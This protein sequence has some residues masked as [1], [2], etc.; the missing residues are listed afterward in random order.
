MLASPPIIKSCDFDGPPVRS[1][2]GHNPQ[3]VI[4]PCP[5]REPA[6]PN[7]HVAVDHHSR[8]PRA[9]VRLRPRR[10]LC[11][12]LPADDVL[13][14]CMKKLMTDAMIVFADA[15]RLCCT[16]SR[17]ACSVSRALLFLDKMG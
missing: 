8:A 16:C 6:C 14:E 5:R 2:D 4:T 1:R 15:L 12:V 17:R 7:V 10:E 9:K 3:L 13:G 11:P